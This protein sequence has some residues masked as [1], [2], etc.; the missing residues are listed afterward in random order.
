MRESSLLPLRPLC[1]FSASSVLISP[2][3]FLTSLP[4]YFSSP[5]LPTAYTSHQSTPAPL[6]APATTPATSPDRSS[7]TGRATVHVCPATLSPPPQSAPPSFPAPAF[8][9]NLIS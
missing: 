3:Y 8:P 4:I 7:P 6:P 2:L 5:A 9:C 1:S